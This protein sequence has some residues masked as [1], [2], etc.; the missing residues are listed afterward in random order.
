MKRKQE[1][2]REKVKSLI[3]E[4]VEQMHQKFVISISEEL[5][6]SYANLISN[7][8]NQQ[9]NW[10]KEANE[11]IEKEH[12]IAMYNCQQEAEQLEDCMKEINKLSEEL[13]N[14]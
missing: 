11:Q 13:Q 8:Q 7:L 4:M 6:K 14:A 1:E 3:P 5:D 12:S 2:S 9:S 10:L